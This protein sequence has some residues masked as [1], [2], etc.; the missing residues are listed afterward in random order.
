MYD[1]TI[2]GGGISALVSAIRIRKSYPWTKIAICEKNDYL[3]GR[4]LTERFHGFRV[5][6]GGSM[7][8][9]TD[10]RVMELC[11]EMGLGIF[12]V[13]KTDYLESEAAEA[14]NAMVDAIKQRAKKYEERENYDEITV[15]RF[16]EEEFSP[17]DTKR[18]LKY[19]IY[20]DFLGSSLKEFMLYYPPEDLYQPEGGRDGLYIIKGGYGALIDRLVE[21]IRKDQNIRIYLKT[22]VK[23]VEF[24]D[25][26]TWKVMTSM[27]VLDTSMIIW[28]TDWSGR[29]ALP[30]YP[31]GLIEEYLAPVPFFRA[32]GYSKESKLKGG[33]ITGGDLEKVFPLMKHVFQLAYSETSSAERLHMITK[34]KSKEEQ[35]DIFQRLLE[36]EVPE[37]I[38]GDL[39]I[40]DVLLKYWKAGIHQYKRSPSDE[41]SEEIQKPFFGFYMVGE[42]VVRDNKG[43]TEGALQSVEE[44][45]SRRKF[46]KPT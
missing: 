27:G 33:L 18:F 36:V 19:A 14:N 22:K 15:R 39:K 32:A 20:R 16:M 40:D 42:M 21:R 44:F 30:D 31:R 23:G 28:A 29:K 45:M 4:L 25:E 11:K 3:G 8:R 5:P 1:I 10:R 34:G 43:W 13:E 35:I 2:V 6:Q 38:R 24:R 7:V 46:A 17:E 12:P 37:S 26:K 9:G 41:V